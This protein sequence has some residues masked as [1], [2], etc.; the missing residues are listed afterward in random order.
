MSGWSTL[1]GLPNLSGRASGMSSTPLWN[2]EFCVECIVFPW[3]PNSFFLTEFI[4]KI[5][6][7]NR[8]PTTATTMSCQCDACVA[9]TNQCKCTENLCGNPQCDAK[10]AGQ[11]TWPKTRGHWRKQ[12]HQQYCAGC[13]KF[14]I[15]GDFW[16]YPKAKGAAKAAAPAASAEGEGKGKGKGAESADIRAITEQMDQLAISVIRLTQQIADQQQQIT[17]QQEKITEQQEKMAEQTRWSGQHADAIQVLEN[18]IHDQEQEI[19]QLKQK[20]IKWQ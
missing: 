18:K 15:P 8:A 4:T 13:W 12:W 14:H 1:G 9:E 10:D 20:Q 2:S 11:C 5:C 7:S 19:W 6:L 3:A 17:E 16:P